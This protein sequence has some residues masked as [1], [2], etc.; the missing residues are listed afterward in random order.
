MNRINIIGAGAIGHLWYSYLKLAGQDVYLYSR[1]NRQEKT[2]NLIH[3]DSS[4]QVNVTYQQLHSWQEPELILICVK[5]PQLAKL[6]QDLKSIVKTKCP[7]ILMMNGM[8]LT[9]VVHSQLP[10]HPIFHAYLTHGVYLT[11]ESIVHAGKG[12]TSLGNISHNIQFN[13]SHLEPELKGQNSSEFG[14]TENIEEIIIAL[15]KSLPDVLWSHTHTEDMLTKLAVNAVINPLTALS[16]QTNGSILVDG[17]LSNS[18]QALFDEVYAI[19]R[20]HLPLSTSEQ[21]QSTVENIAQKTAKNKSSMLQ[22]ILKSNPTEIDF[23]NG[24]LINVLAPKDQGFPVNREL[25]NQIKA[26]ELKNLN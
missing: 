26:L 18:A 15:N 12:I 7:I 24:Y 21:I 8:G 23:I 3:E 22:D 19:I 6:C 4:R 5:A 11:E 20:G 16:G 1:S 2:L 14:L 17:K 10:F 9:E 13:S 25:I